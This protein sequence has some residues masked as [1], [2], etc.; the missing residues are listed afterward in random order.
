MKR[1]LFL[2]TIIF[3]CTFFSIQKINAQAPATDPVDQIIS[4]EVIPE[5]PRQYQDVSI[6]IT[7]Y[8]YDLSRAKISWYINNALRDS[9]VGKRSFS[10]TTGGVGS[11]SKIRYQI[12]TSEGVAFEK[13]ITITPGDVTLIWES[14]GYIPPFFKGKSLFSFEG[15]I[16]LIAVP[17]LLNANGVKYKPEELI[18]TWKRGMGTDTD[19]SGYGKNVF[20][21]NGNII[22]TAEEIEVEVS[23]IQRTTRAV[24]SITIEPQ[25]TEILAYENNPSLGI[26]FNRA[27]NNSFDLKGTE[28]SFT[29]IPYYFNNPDSEGEYSWYVNGQKSPETSRN[30]TFR[31]TE[32]LEGY[33]KIDFDLSS[34]KRIMQSA[35]SK[36]DIYFGAKNQNSATN[37]F[38]SF[39]GY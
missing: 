39:F 3:L 8:S 1:F 34:Q 2:F 22:S 15:R 12:T 31:N 36:F 24:A 23:D 20:Y 37:I 21:W 9:G 35:S 27:I 6:D 14:A 29:A 38:K 19:A 32:G 25:P 26:M 11:V 30:I 18:Y 28:G 17:N 13:T 4:V 7:S 33:S 5:T 10:F 16:R